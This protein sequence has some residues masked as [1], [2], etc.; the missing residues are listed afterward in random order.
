[1]AKSGNQSVD[2]LVVVNKQNWEDAM[3]VAKI[4]LGSV[5]ILTIISSGA[6]AQEDQTSGKIIKIDQAN[7]KITLEHKLGGTVGAAAAKN[8]V[9]T[10]KM[11]DGLTFNT[12]KVGDPVVFTE[13]RIGDVWTVTKIQKQ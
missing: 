7:G 8:L 10:Y 1:L 3:A 11:G 5:A 2:C 4:I 12:L 13:A 9:D 6:L